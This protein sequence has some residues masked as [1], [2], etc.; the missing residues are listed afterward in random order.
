MR[1]GQ[2]SA[3]STPEGGRGQK[4]VR[5]QVRVQTPGGAWMWK[6]ISEIFGSGTGRKKPPK[7]K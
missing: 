4:P 7:K 1:H 5:S 6:Q 3:G 2:P